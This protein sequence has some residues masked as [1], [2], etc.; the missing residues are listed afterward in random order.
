MMAYRNNKTPKY[1]M[2]NRDNGVL[3]AQRYDTFL[4]LASVFEKNF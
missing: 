1:V 2:N 4:T 3:R